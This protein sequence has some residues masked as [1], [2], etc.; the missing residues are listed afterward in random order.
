MNCWH[1]CKIKDLDKSHLEGLMLEWCMWIMMLQH[2]AEANPSNFLVWKLLLCYIHDS[3]DPFPRFLLPV[4]SQ[5][6]HASA[7]KMPNLRQFSR[8]SASSC[9]QQNGNG[10]SLMRLFIYCSS[11][12]CGY[13]SRRKQGIV[14]AS[15]SSYSTWEAAHATHRA[16]C[17]LSCC[18]DFSS[19]VCSLTFSPSSQFLL[20]CLW[21]SL[22][23]TLRTR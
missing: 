12:S 22:R 18:C 6:L 3:S 19:V 14:G 10:Y 16:L 4:T 13:W 7:R 8:C 1:F 9:S 17:L 2:G 21:S 20:H 5:V 11:N 23:T 15:M